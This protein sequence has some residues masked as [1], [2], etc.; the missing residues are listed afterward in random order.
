MPPSKHRFHHLVPTCSPLVLWCPKSVSAWELDVVPV[1]VSAWVSQFEAV[2]PGVVHGVF[3][4]KNSSSG[5]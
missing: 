2:L 3:T 4:L 1:T 5:V